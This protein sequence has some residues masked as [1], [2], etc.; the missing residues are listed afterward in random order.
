MKTELRILEVGLRIVNGAWSQLQPT[1]SR[2]AERDDEMHLALQS[3]DCGLSELDRI[4]RSRLR[5]SV[6]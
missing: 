6:A 3:V 5:Q 2:M 1:L 4:I